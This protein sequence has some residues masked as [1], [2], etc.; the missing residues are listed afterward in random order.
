MLNEEDLVVNDVSSS[1]DGIQNVQR[2]I[3]EYFPVRFGE[4][5]MLSFTE[6]V[7]DNSSVDRNKRESGKYIQNHDS[8]LIG[9]KHPW[10]TFSKVMQ[11][12]I[13]FW[14]RKWNKWQSLSWTTLVDEKL[15]LLPGDIFQTSFCSQDA[16]SLQNL[17][18]SYANME[19]PDEQE[20]SEFQSKKIIS[21]LSTIAPIAQDVVDVH[22]KKK[23]DLL[24]S[25]DQIVGTTNHS[26]N[27]REPTGTMS[28]SISFLKNGELVKYGLEEKVGKYR[29][30]VSCHSR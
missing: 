20:C 11:K 29:L 10:F 12:V 13:N 27:S 7:G 28:S 3:R 17:W 18:I 8:Q 30:T 25:L 1:K 15:S 2:D 24:A 26:G 14:Q 22:S 23:L 16:E 19:N 21:T 6:L 9:E 4:D 5:T